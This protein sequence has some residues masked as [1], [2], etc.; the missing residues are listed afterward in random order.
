MRQ[1]NLSRF[2]L[3]LLIIMGF[4]LHS[5]GTIELP[6][7]E[8]LENRAYDMR[9]LATMPNTQE[10]RIVI[11]DIDEKSLDA[12]GRWP[13]G[14][15]K[16]ALL[17][18]KLF[19]TYYASVVGFDVLF[20]EEDTSSGLN[21][22]NDLANTELKDE[23]S[24]LD[25]Y[26]KIK[27]TLE[28]DKIFAQSLADRDTVLGYFFVP[29]NSPESGI[30]KGVLPGPVTSY[31]KLNVKKLPIPTA[32]GYGGNLAILQKNAI[33]GGFIDKPVVDSDGVVR[34]VYLFQEFAGQLYASLP[35][36]MIKALMGNPEIEFTIAPG[37]ENAPFNLGFEWLTIGGLKIP[38]D[39][40]S[41][42]PVPYIGPSGS[43]PYISATDVM[44]GDVELE[45]LDGAI[46]L[47]GSSAA[48]LLDLRSTPVQGIY[49]GVEIHANVLAG[50]LD[51]SIMQRPGY[52]Q[53]VEFISLII[54]GIL[55]LIL[56]PLMSALVV[57]VFAVVL[58]ASVIGI[59]LYFWNAL[60]LIPI[61]SSVLL[62][63][64]IFIQHVSYSF[65]LEQNTKRKLHKS[66]GQ[67]IPPELVDELSETEEAFSLEGESREMT[68]LFSDVRGFTSIAENL[69]PKQL[70][71]L[72]NA[73]LT[74]MTGIIHEQR[75]TID[76]Y[77]GDAI[78]SF[79]GAPIADKNHAS[80][81]VAAAI[82]MK[83][84]LP[85]INKKFKKNNWPTIN[86]GIGL[87]TG[88]MSVGNMGSAFRMA[89]T[90]M[91]DAVNL[92]S[93][94]EGLTK[95]YGVHII[96]SESTA[97]AASEYAYRSLDLVKV[98]GKE[99]AVEI[100]EPLGLKEDLSAYASNTLELYVQALASYRK[101]DWKP[102]QEKFNILQKQSE[103]LLYKIYLDRIH[104]FAQDPPGVDWDG[105]Y[106]FT[107]K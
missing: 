53:G 55:L 37:Y 105:V 71:Q 68:V 99:E 69:E 83:H 1:Y 64:S 31:E 91:G 50:I 93:R 61:A 62:I 104:Q 73:M 29:E 81:A 82:K 18:D 72:M 92:G 12:E 21:V 6:F 87:N 40:E 23:L 4:G 107:S 97:R 98:A 11:V 79:W 42:I 26:H 2:L 15:D 59:N 5:M 67:Y 54:I 48:G 103:Q 25:V 47:I 22:L 95:K 78:M 39:A 30:K 80:H 57:G 13:W 28:W 86:I 63:M 60:I 24:F 33:G 75:G 52:I 66:F 27:P 7:V 36:A 96:V 84:E 10:K 9:L 45:Q 20:I 41:A 16:L 38:I 106:T 58:L 34:K 77:M 35:L 70:S 19:D 43:Y 46:I 90:V 51:E 100:F 32:T 3:G 65:L 56:L 49:P 85:K 101:Q 102:A 76:K 44:H 74:P 17:M 8:Q 89:Y 14:R 94:L 88:V